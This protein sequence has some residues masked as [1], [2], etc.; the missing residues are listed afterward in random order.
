MLVPVKDLGQAID[1]FHQELLIYPLWLCP[2]KMFHTPVKGLANPTGDQDEMFVDVGAY[3]VPKQKGFNSSETLRRVEKFVRDVKGFQA[4][5]ADTY[6]TKQEFRE[7][8]DHTMYDVIRAKYQCDKAFPEI[9][10]K[11]SKAAR[12]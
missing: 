2:M 11:I 8:F 6:M 7:M 4:L 9:F 1:V 3:G 10:D 5:Y 12:L